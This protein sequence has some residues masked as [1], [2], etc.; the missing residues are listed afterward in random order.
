VLKHRLI[1]A[2][3]LGVPATAALSMSVSVVQAA[4]ECR[5]KPDS[6]APSGSR[7]V[8]RINRA[9]DRHCWFLSSK[10][11]GPHSQL[12]RRH[13]HLPGEAEAARQDQQRDSDL[14]TASAPTHNTDVAVAAK[15]PAVSQ[16]S[17]S[18][19]E[20]SSGDLVPRSVPTILY[21]LPPASSA[22]SHRTNSPCATCADRYAGRRQQIERGSSCR[23]S[24]SRSVFCWRSF[25]LHT[26]C[27]PECA[28]ALGSGCFIVTGQRH[29]TSQREGCSVALF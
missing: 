27:P 11:V 26:S 15:P 4:E 10:A 20:Q 21:R 28:H 13:R 12:A 9:N 6:T 1:Q 16:A 5:L 3:L 22:N 17:A 25:P 8:Y 24:G 7:W 2:L 18:S 23:S 29:G 19:V 14:Q